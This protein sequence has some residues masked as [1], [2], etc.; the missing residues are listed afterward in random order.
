M[1][2]GVIYVH[3]M[4][5]TIGQTVTELEILA[6]AGHPEDFLNRIEILPL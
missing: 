2:A 3:P 6:E 5:L 1:F 4:Q